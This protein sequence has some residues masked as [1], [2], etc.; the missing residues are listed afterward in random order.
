MEKVGPLSV[1]AV[2]VGGG[3]GGV[4]AI[5]KLRA[6]GLSVHLFEA[7]SRLGGVWSNN[8]Y[9]GACTDSEC[10]FYQL[11]IHEVYRDWNFSERY[12]GY[13]EMRAYFDH[14][15][16]VL[17]IARDATFNAEVV[18]AVFTSDTNTWTVTTKAGHVAQS[19][20]LLVCTGSSYRP[21]VPQFNDMDQFAGELHHSTAWP[22]KQV[23]VRDKRVAI[24]GQGSSGLQMVQSLSTEAKHMTVFVRTPNIAAP[25]RQRKMSAEEQEQMKGWYDSLLRGACRNSFGGFVFNPAPT[26]STWNISSE[27][28]EAWFQECWDRSAFNFISSGFSDVLFDE[29]ANR[30]MYDFWVKK[31]R[32]RIR[33]PVKRDILVPLDPP[34][35]MLTKR[36]GAENDYYECMDQENVRVVDVKSTPIESFT[37]EGIRIGGSQPEDLGFDI[38]ALATGFDA[39][40]GAIST[41]GVEGTDGI[42]LGQRWKDGVDTHLGLMC[43]KCPNMWMVYGPQGEHL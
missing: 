34:H 7:S 28:R 1:D 26:N 10:P 8:Q 38:I 35:H 41:M 9:P 40:T 6:M 13:T 22:D 36:S 24:I 37:R 19:R 5:Y 17:D 21:Y 4:Y 39:Y 25:A 23:D 32:P 15:D 20:Y 11:S 33:D 14:V 2:V 29:K 43:P 12:S 27:D 30:V 3:F 31:T 18:K 16:K 42:E